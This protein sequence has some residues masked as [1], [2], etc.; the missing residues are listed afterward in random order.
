MIGSVRIFRSI[1]VCGAITSAAN[2]VFAQ[3]L[4]VKLGLWET[5]FVAQTSGMPP[6]DTSNLTPEQRAR[7]EAAMEMAKNRAATPHTVRTC[8]TSRRRLCAPRRHPARPSR[9]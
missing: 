6:I 8:L 5:T 1:V 9:P 3:T 4:N 7:I 2:A